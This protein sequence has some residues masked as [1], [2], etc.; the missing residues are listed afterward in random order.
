MAAPRTPED[1]MFRRVVKNNEI[2]KGNT[3]IMK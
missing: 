2:K 1:R 3:P